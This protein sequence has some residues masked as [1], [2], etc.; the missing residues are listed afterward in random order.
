MRSS[1]PQT[2]LLLAL[3]I[4]S[5][6]AC[7]EAS[8]G[9]TEAEAESECLHGADFS[10][11]SSAL[12]ID[13][14][15]LHNAFDPTAAAVYDPR[16]APSR[17]RSCT[18]PGATDVGRTRNNRRVPS[19]VLGAAPYPLQRLLWDRHPGPTDQSVRNRSRGVLR[20]RCVEQTLRDR[21][22]A[23][24]NVAR[25]R[26]VTAQ[27]HLR[28]SGS[29]LVLLLRRRRVRLRPTRRRDRRARGGHR[30]GGAS[31]DTGP[32]PLVRRTRPHARLA[33][34]ASSSSTPRAHSTSTRSASNR[35]RFDGGAK[36]PTF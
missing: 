34:T 12:R 5:I 29:L 26:R 11:N 15:E 24:L 22:Q 13:D 14:G 8:D 23:R 10:L 27:Y 25:S 1:E 3:G 35:N 30:T 16:E 20:R 6:A 33:P 17:V 4:L 7:G 28:G 2:S 21:A 18:T 19:R 31:S 9:A 32:S 36:A